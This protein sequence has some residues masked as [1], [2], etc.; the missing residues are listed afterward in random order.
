MTALQLAH[1]H[2]RSNI[3]YRLI[4]MASESDLA[5]QY[6]ISKPSNPI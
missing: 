1:G 5:R 2:E 6:Y 3:P 4:P